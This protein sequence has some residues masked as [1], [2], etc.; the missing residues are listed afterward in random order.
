MEP[1]GLLSKSRI[2]NMVPK[3][4]DEE[5][6]AR[7]IAVY[8]EINYHSHLDPYRSSMPA[9]P[10]WSRL[11]LYILENVFQNQKS[12]QNAN[13]IWK[14]YLVRHLVRFLVRHLDCSRPQHI[15]NE[16]KI[17]ADVK[18]VADPRE[19]ESIQ[20]D[21]NNLCVCGKMCGC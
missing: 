17:S 18:M 1:K 14:A 16:I 7:S 4:Q 21:L 9:I 19:N 5:F 8:G 6:A 2:P 20:S 12:Y 15:K 13:Q 10:S 11:A 3:G